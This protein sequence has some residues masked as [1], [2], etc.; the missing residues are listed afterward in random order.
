MTVIVDYGVGNLFS[1]ASSLKKIGEPSVVSS[2]KRVIEGADRVIL[3]GVGAFGDAMKKLEDSGL[4][5]VIIE[6]ASKGVPLLGICLG[7]QLLFERSFEYGEHK[8]LGL[9][10]GE[11]RPIV[12]D[13]SLKI[14]HMGWN[15]LKLKGG[16]PLFS[17]IKDGT[18][19]YF[20]HSY[21]AVN[22]GESVIAETEY[23]IP[24]TAAAA[25]ANVMGCQFHPEKSG[26][27]GLDILRAFV[28]MKEGDL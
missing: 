22:C 14:P 3:P 5:D 16:H 6:A 15:S 21:H 18:Y 20:V 27:A 10:K 13:P 19:V 2:E 24:V 12:T 4:K 7:M 25:S 28:T 23:G 17:R 9:L 26:D 8:G 11:V 1:L